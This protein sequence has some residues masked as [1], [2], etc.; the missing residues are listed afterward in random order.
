M[1]SELLP[2]RREE[3]AA[4]FTT[5]QPGAT[6]VKA[7]KLG[8]LQVNLVDKA[9][10]DRKSHAIAV[11]MRPRLVEIGHAYEVIAT[12]AIARFHRQLGYDVHFLIGMDE[13]GQKVAQ[14]AAERGITPQAFVDEIAGRFQA[15]WERLGISYDQFIRTTSPAHHAG[16]RSLIERIFERSPDDFYERLKA[17]H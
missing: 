10:R 5:L 8:D 1:P 16:V 15:M 12:D 6:T 7:G 17:M 2:D 9:H 13:H 3:K 14:A 11:T 4:F